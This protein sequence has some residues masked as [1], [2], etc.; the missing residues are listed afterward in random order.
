MRRKSA[1]NSGDEVF[2]GSKQMIEPH[3]AFDAAGEHVLHE[4]LA[5][6]AGE[7]AERAVPAGHQEVF[8]AHLSL[9]GADEARLQRVLGGYRQIA[10]GIN[11]RHVNGLR[12]ER[13]LEVGYV[14]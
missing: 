2:A 3:P 12:L 11:N 7:G 4:I 9:R 10:P 1:G 5:A 8:K 6:Q 14:I 13:R